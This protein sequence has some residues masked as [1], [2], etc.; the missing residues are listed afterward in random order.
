M[1]HKQSLKQMEDARRRMST[2]ARAKLRRNHVE[3][4]ERLRLAAIAEDQALYE[5]RYES[6]LA[7]RNT[8]ADNAAKRR[9]SFAFRNGD[10]RRI[11]ELFSQMEED[12]VRSK[13]AIHELKWART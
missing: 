3:G 2:E 12:K 8:M 1:E 6:S 5:E 4:K 9:Q 13:P 10:A 11:R 7:T